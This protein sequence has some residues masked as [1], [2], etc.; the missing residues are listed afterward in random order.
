VRFISNEDGT[1]NTVSEF[2]EYETLS[3][4]RAAAKAYQKAYKVPA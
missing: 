2:Q 1:I 3:E 4:A